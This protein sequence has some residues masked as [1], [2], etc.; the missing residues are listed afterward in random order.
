MLFR[1]ERL[2]CTLSKEACGKRWLKAEEIDLTK[3]VSVTKQ[4]Y[5]VCKD[6]P[7]GQKNSK[8]AGDYDATF[9]ARVPAFMVVLPKQPCR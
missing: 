8:E 2:N 7:I 6:C 3:K 5:L 4:L 9:P 1:C